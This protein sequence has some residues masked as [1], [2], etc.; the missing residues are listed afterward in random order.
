[1]PGRR[2][3][4]RQEA[5]PAWSEQQTN[6]PRRSSLGPANAGRDWKPKS[7]SAHHHRPGQLFQPP[8]PPAAAGRCHS[9]ALATCEPPRSGGRRSRTTTTTGS[10]GLHPSFGGG[11]GDRSSIGWHC[12]SDHFRAARRS[13]GPGRLAPGVNGLGGAGVV[14]LLLG[15]RA[16][17]VGVYTRIKLYGLRGP[18]WRKIRCVCMT[19]AS[20]RAPRAAA[21]QRQLREQQSARLLLSHLRNASSRSACARCARQARRWTACAPS[22]TARHQAGRRRPQH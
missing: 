20:A 22:P 21:S 11:T 17:A 9:V 6:K 14:G 8:Q 5:R 16:G 19:R 18:T 12:L 3:N 15:G 7:A 1:M 2:L 10:G 13:P 4:R